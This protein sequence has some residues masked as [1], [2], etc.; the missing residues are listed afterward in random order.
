MLR[1]FTV[2]SF[3]TSKQRSTLLKYTI[4]ALPYH[5]WTVGAKI[6]ILSR[7]AMRINVKVKLMRTCAI[8]QNKD[9]VA[10]YVFLQSRATDCDKG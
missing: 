1:V 10:L 6:Q 3:N 2:W 8:Q 5:R 9:S 7:V 4:D